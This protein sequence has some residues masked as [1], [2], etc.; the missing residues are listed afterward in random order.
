MPH[1]MSYRNTVSGIDME[2][3]QRVS[4]NFSVEVLGTDYNPTTETVLYPNQLQ[5]GQPIWSVCE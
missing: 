3:M 4:M 5:R 2:P 1:A